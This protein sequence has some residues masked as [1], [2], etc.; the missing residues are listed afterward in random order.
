MNLQAV[1][2]VIAFSAFNPCSLLRAQSSAPATP[3]IQIPE[4][5]RPAMEAAFKEGKNYFIWLVE[6]SDTFKAKRAGL[7]FPHA[8]IE[9]YCVGN[10]KLPNPKFKSTIEMLTTPE[11]N[12]PGGAKVS[13]S[14]TDIQKDAAWWTAA[15]GGKPF[16]M[17]FSYIPQDR[18]LR[19]TSQV[20]LYLISDADTKSHTPVSNVLSVKLEIP[21]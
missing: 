9:C 5:V 11:K 21:E 16:G 15:Q 13:Y 14:D 2:A 17:V 18:A 3:A 10:P 8:L 12:A 7:P 6:N 1:L 19:G 4:R 20:R